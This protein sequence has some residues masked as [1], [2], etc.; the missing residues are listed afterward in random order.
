MRFRPFCLVILGLLAS[1]CD[2]VAGP[3]GGAAVYALVRIGDAVLPAPG[4]PGTNFPLILG[5]T[6][7]LPASRP[8]PDSSLVVSRVQVFKQENGQIDRSTG[9]FGATRR[10]DSLIVDNCPFG[11]FCAAVDL[12]YSPF[13]LRFEGDS[14]FELVPEGSPLKPRVYGRVIAR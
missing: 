13:V 8:R 12:V 4:W 7:A 6:L 11:A 14:L 9:R 5:D 10:G 1:A 2:D 3:G